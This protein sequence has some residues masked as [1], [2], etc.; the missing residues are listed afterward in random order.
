MTA[1]RWIAI[2]ATLVVV[3]LFVRF[4]VTII[5]ADAPQAK[6]EATDPVAATGSLAVPVEGVA[7]SSLVDTYTQS[8]ENGMRVHNAI[9]ILAPRGT[10]VLAAAP[11]TIE[12][13]FRSERGGNTVYIRSPD[14]HW[15]YYYAHLDAYAPGLREGRQLRTGEAIGTVGST[16]NA[17]EDAPHLH[18]AINRMAPGQRW[19]EGDA[20]NPYPL[21][22][23]VSR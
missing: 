7:R 10:R 8:R 22:K 13:I 1:G 16:G 20:I 14:L 3:A 19:F 6:M 17:S 2:V 15:L 11:G 18:F 4:C 12:K 23:P 9:D 21:L 5:P